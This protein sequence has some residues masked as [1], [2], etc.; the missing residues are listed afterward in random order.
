MLNSGSRFD[1]GSRLLNPALVLSRAMA[2]RVPA[3]A[4][5]AMS[6]LAEAIRLSLALAEGAPPD[7]PSPETENLVA[8]AT[9]STPALGTPPGATESGGLAPDAAESAGAAG[10]AGVAPGPA[11]S[12]G[13]APDPGPAESGG[14]APDAATTTSPPVKKPL[15]TSEAGGAPAGSG[16][17]APGPTAT[18]PES[19]PIPNYRHRTTRSGAAQTPVYDGGP[20]YIVFNAQVPC[21][22][23]YWPTTWAEMERDLGIPPKRLAGRLS[24]YGVDLRKVTSEREARELWADWGGGRAFD[25]R[26]G[27]PAPAGTVLRMFGHPSIP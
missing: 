10:S 25:F 11:E 22:V 14:V 17:V 5:E 6:D 21:T 20:G 26:R 15:P 4:D 9:I 13:V 19:R 27:Q 24:E 1:S 3:S 12:G 23:G 2:C 8:D 7:P 16:G 18:P